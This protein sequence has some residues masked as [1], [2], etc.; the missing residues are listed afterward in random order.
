MNKELRHLQTWLFFLSSLRKVAKGFSALIHFFT[1]RRALIESSESFYSLLLIAVYLPAAH[2][3]AVSCGPIYKFIDIPCGI[4]QKESYFMWK[5]S[6]FHLFAKPFNALFR[7]LW[8][9]S[10]KPQQTRNFFIMEIP[11]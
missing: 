8:L 9:I 1:K 5:G 7:S 3:L 10:I 6:F 2:T 4:P 11:F